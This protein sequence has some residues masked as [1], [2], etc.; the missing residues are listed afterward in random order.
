MSR[1]IPSD[2][3]IIPEHDVSAPTTVEGFLTSLKL[4]HLAPLFLTNGFDDLKFLQDIE[5]ADLQSIGV[6]DPATQQT[7][8]SATRRL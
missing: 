3:A 2:T 7:V 4:G 6:T 5:L 1:F 8:L